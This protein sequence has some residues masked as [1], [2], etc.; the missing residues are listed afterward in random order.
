[1]SRLIAERGPFATSCHA[2]AVPKIGSGELG[3]TAFG[4]SLAQTERYKIASGSK[5]PKSAIS[6]AM[7]DL[8]ES[9]S[10]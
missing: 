1:V 9:L 6:G 8:A 7:S 4:D 10:F 5:I 3:S 2:A